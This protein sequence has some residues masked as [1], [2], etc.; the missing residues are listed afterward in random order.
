MCVPFCGGISGWQHAVRMLQTCGYCLSRSSEILLLITWIW[1][2]FSTEVP[3]GPI[4]YVADA[5]QGQFWMLAAAQKCNIATASWP[6]QSFSLAG[7]RQGWSAPGGLAF[8]DMLAF[9][10]I[11]GIQF[12]LLENVPEVWSDLG[13]R[14]TLIANV[15]SEG[16]HFIF[17]EVLART[18]RPCAAIKIHRRHHEVGARSVDT[19]ACRQG[20]ASFSGPIAF[21]AT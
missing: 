17:A 18:R 20:Q 11:C 16:Y 15:L 21:A 13:L 1:V 5:S 7:G 9:C 3:P 4:A 10:S 14:A 19:S 6:C 12:V 8:K 2:V